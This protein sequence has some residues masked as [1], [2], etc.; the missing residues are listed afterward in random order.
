MAN[1]LKNGGLPL[2][3]TALTDS[4]S[5]KRDISSDPTM[6]TRRQRELLRQGEMEIDQVLDESD[7]AVPVR[8]G[9]S[10]PRINGTW[11][12]IC[13]FLLRHL[14]LPSHPDVKDK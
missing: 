4:L 1:N 13:R 9:L 5:L 3:A 8:H 11:L 6:L 10:D 14:R 2:S 12:D 7:D